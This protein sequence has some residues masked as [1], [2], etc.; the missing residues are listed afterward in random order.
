MYLVCYQNNLV[1]YV[2]PVSGDVQVTND[3]VTWTDGKLGNIKLDF[4]LVDNP[5][6]K[7]DTVT[8]E[9]LAADRKSEFMDEIEQLK[10]RLE[11]SEMALI[12]MMDMWGK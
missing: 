9:M 1:T 6:S 3:A 2:T 7:G 10:T 11:T 5:V 12:Q 4:I 8:D